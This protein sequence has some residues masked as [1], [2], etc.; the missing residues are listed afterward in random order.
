MVRGVV[1][2]FVLATLLATAAMAAPIWAK[3]AVAL[4]PRC[5]GSPRVKARRIVS[6]D[7]TVTIEPRCRWSAALDD[8]FMVLRVTSRTGR[9]QEVE[10]KHKKDDMWRPQELLWSPDSK[11]FFINGSP[12]AYA[13]FAVIVY[14]LRPDGFVAPEV[15][16]AAQRDMVATFPP[17]KAAYRDTGFCKE[18]EIDADYNMSGLAWTRGSSAI[19]VF[20]EVPCSGSYGG[21]G[22]QVMGYEVAIPSGRILRR[23]TARETKK[24]WQS[25]MAWNIEYPWTTGLWPA[26][27][28]NPDMASDRS[29]ARVVYST[30]AG[31]VCP[32]CG[33]P[34]DDCRCSKG[35]EQAVPD[36]IV[37]K[38][39]V[40]KAGRN[41]K[42]VTV[43]FGLP[44]NAMFLK[45][46]C[47][48]L[49]RGCGT[50]GA[51]ADDTVELQGDHR[52]RIRDLL[53]KKGFVVKG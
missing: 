29:N 17:C 21:I 1:I 3:R 50:G 20:A 26:L 27:P 13:G 10:V 52:E 11:A 44:R 23:L 41:G 15:T 7:G 19:A 45:D 14:E 8:E 6:P 25:N 47:K 38:L 4:E 36:R 43:V 12:S 34:S 49:K 5:D 42:T 40:E 31:R 9:V 2:Q 48:E 37:A 28:I 22:C 35:R 39:R 18:L 16:G 53:L 24:R 33:W 32:G 51:V 46:L 30:G